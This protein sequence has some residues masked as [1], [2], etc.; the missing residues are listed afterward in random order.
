MFG[1]GAQ[2]GD[3]FYVIIIYINFQVIGLIPR[4]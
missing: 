2:E 3:R 1:D 4:T